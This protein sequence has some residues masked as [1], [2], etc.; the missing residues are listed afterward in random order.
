MNKYKWRLKT[1]PPAQF[2]QQFPEISP[3]V[4]TLLYDRGLTE[5]AQIEEFLSP[6][7]S[8]DICDP[9]LF[10]QMKTAVERIYQAKVKNEP[11]VIFGDYDADGVCGSAI[12]ARV[13]KEL[14]LN[15]TTYLPDREKEGYGLN[16]KAVE[17]IARGGAKLIIT[18]DCGISNAAE[19]A[20][21]K[22]LGLDLI[23]TDHHHV[24]INSPEALAIIHPA[25]DKNY[26]FKFL[27]GGGVAFKLASGL[28][29][30][31]H[32][33]AGENREGL[34]KWLLDLAAISTVADMV[35]LIGENRTLVKFG[36]VV[37][38]KTKNL[39]LKKLMEVAGIN[40]EKLD[41]FSLGYQVAPRINAAGRM[42]HA[43][44]AYE[45]LTTDNVEEAITL[46]HQLNKR[47]T[48]R[49]QLTEKLVTEAKAQL[50]SLAPLPLL[51]I[52]GGENWNPGI[53]GLVAS[54]LTQDFARPA[55]VY[56]F[57]GIRYV[58]SG[59][60]IKEFNLIEALDKLSD[61][62]IKY[63][64]HAG[65]AGFSISPEKFEEFKQKIIALATEQLTG[66]ELIPTLTIDQELTLA[67]VDWPTVNA[68]EQFSP[69]GEGNLKPRFLI[70]DLT[71]VLAETVGETGSHL[72]LMVKQGLL[73][74]KIICFGF[75]ELCPLLAPGQKIDAVCELGVNQWN[76]NQ[77]LQLSLIDLKGHEE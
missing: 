73:T 43:N 16:I 42:D 28:V 54:K 71:V 72:R 46:A 65:A 38:A 35:P 61:Y 18:V 74:R 56:S 67:Q 21:V 8:H 5:Q 31:R 47:N 39:G 14:G 70:K 33:T 53:I 41:T 59:R 6:D 25:W 58:A 26:P 19:A 49:Q 7:Y 34:E 17:E 15:F 77:E 57:D 2:F 52:V 62:F 75:G 12:L 40:P 32:F 45:L 30:D 23:I 69:Y 55:L 64:G 63:G 51:L 68:L 37:L 50:K 76:G 24:P 36:L 13:F 22:E 10:S 29:K 44:T 27:A 3:A 60:S 48:E 11:V 66:R 1:A 20:R 9:Y 4:L